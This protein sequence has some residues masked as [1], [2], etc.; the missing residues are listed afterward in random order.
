M[1]L[2]HI[3]HTQCWQRQ[4]LRTFRQKCCDYKPAEMIGARYAS[5][6]QWWRLCLHRG[7]SCKWLGHLDYRPCVGLLAWMPH[8]SGVSTSKVDLDFHGSGGGHDAGS[9]LALACHQPTVGR[10]WQPTRSTWMRSW[11]R[12]TAVAGWMRKWHRSSWMQ[13]SNARVTSQAEPV[14]QMWLRHGA[15]GKQ[16]L[17]CGWIPGKPGLHGSQPGLTPEPEPK[18]PWLVGS[19]I[20]GTTVTASQLHAFGAAHC[21]QDGAILVGWANASYVQDRSCVTHAVAEQVG[22]SP[23]G[24]DTWKLL[25]ILFG[26][27]SSQ[28]PGLVRCAGDDAGE[29]P[30]GWKAMDALQFIESQRVQQWRQTHGLE[31]D[32]DFAFAFVNWEQASSQ[33][34]MLVADQWVAVRSAASDAMLQQVTSAIH[35][36]SESASSSTRQL[37]PKLKKPRRRVRLLPNPAASPEAVT[38]RVDALA[39][40]WIDCR[41]LRP[42][43]R[44]T[45]E[46]HEAWKE[47]CT[48]LAQR[49]I[50]H[51]EAV[52]VN[53]ALK[54]FRELTS[55]LSSRQ[56]CLP[57][58]DV[59]IDHYLHKGTTAPSRALASLRWLVKN[60]EL[61]WPLRHATIPEKIS[62]R[63]MRAQAPVVLP[64]MIGHLEECII[65]RESIHDPT[66]LALLGSWM[67]AMGVLRHKHLER[68]SPRKVALS[69]LHA[70][71]HRGK[72]RIEEWL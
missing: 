2:P 68:T 7:T 10:P 43:G 59:D 41:V 45:P 24:S 35:D 25:L 61:Q 66:W 17:S 50:T 65:A 72:Q 9:L 28:A 19:T 33:A 8:V 38:R 49:Q 40:V 12:P 53:N 32:D 51:A 71:C 46:L 23:N 3:R 55:V 58:E 48:R 31:D 5:G 70:H 15:A 20:H 34:G 13:C 14:Q 64:P 37:H 60:G 27:G 62:T 69:F 6:H 47:A 39:A 52:T 18:G 22:R 16:V 56:R 67:I 1:V 42:T 63:R 4:L 11:W 26:I 44:M 30:G 54:T 57:P 21:Q 29:Q 36:I